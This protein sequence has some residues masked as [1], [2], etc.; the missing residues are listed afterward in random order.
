MGVLRSLHIGFDRSV[1]VAVKFDQSSF[2]NPHTPYIHTDL[3]PGT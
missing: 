2:E 1:V 3:T